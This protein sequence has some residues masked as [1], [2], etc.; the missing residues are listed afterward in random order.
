MGNGVNQTNDLAAT[1]DV[2][3]GIFTGTR[4]FNILVSQFNCE[5]PNKP[6]DS[7][8][9]YFTGKTGT[10]PYW[11][12]CDNL[13]IYYLSFVTIIWPSAELTWV[14]KRHFLFLLIL[15]EEK[16]NGHWTLGTPSNSEIICG[17]K[18]VC[19]IIFFIEKKAMLKIWKKSWVPCRSYLRNSTANPAQFEC[20][21]AG[22][23]VLFS[24]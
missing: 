19:R 5:D 13:F 9:Q 1:V 20:K 14:I 15:V 21:W 12:V 7:C 18:V 23:A 22:L 4:R 24:R 6:P 17:R 10:C 3:F 2:R 11:L 8:A 16:V